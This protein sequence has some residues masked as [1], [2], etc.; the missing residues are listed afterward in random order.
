MKYLPFISGFLVIVA[1][2]SV[3]AAQQPGPAAATG[4]NSP[5]L[6]DIMEAAQSRHIKLW[7]AGKNRNWELAGY[8]AAQIRA[9]LE[10]AATLYAGLPVTKVT[11][12][13]EPLDAVLQA[14]EAKDGAKFTRAFSALTAGCN[15]CHQSI[16]RGYIAI[17]AP[18]SSPFSNQSFAPAA[19]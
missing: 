19:K 18:T 7:F 4:N 13:A 12:M 2:M 15:A 8:E 17:Q 3:A 16:G 6:A 14:V 1:A 10:D 9:R 5:R 11:T